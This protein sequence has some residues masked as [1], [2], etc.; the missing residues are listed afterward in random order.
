MI[1]EVTSN[2]RI[3]KN[4]ASHHSDPIRNY[5]F[6]KG[7]LNIQLHYATKYKVSGNA[8]FKIFRK[9]FKTN[10]S[11]ALKFNDYVFI[12][13]LNGLINKENGFPFYYNVLVLI[14]KYKVFFY[15]V[16]LNFNLLFL[17]NKLIKNKKY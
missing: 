3:L 8:I 2:Y 12:K 13:L 15:L 10:Y 4:S 7:I 6:N 17:I 9:N 16:K 14:F 5:N 1:N 11:S